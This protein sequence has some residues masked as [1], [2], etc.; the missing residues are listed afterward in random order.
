[1]REPT[2]QEAHMHYFAYG[3]NM[4]LAR[5]AERVPSAQA[6]G[7]ARL[8]GH[9]LAWHKV[10][11]DGSGKC[12]VVPS[13]SGDEVWG[14]LYLIDPGH[15]ADLDHIEGVGYGYVAA[16]LTVELDGSPVVAQAYRATDIDGALKPY[17]WYKALVVA[18]ARENDLPEEYVRAL[19]AVAAVRDTDDERRRAHAALLGGGGS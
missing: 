16:T 2:G 11:S 19:D 10:S 4:L 5:L 17:G 14:V 18:G 1:M 8:A 3:S 7:V 6:L 9:R 15:K 12:D 13:Q